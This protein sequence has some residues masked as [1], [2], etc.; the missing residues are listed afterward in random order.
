MDIFEQKPQLHW[1]LSNQKFSTEC[2]LTYPNCLAQGLTEDFDLLIDLASVTFLNVS[3][4]EH[5]YQLIRDF[6]L[7]VCVVGSF[8]I[9]H[10]S[11]RLQD[12]DLI[13]FNNY[14]LLAFITH[15]CRLMQMF[16]RNY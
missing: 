7:F 2:P 5:S 4:L 1:A 14:C 8:V 13:L 6:R 9:N 15:F 3:C 16:R 11:N 12:L 10:L